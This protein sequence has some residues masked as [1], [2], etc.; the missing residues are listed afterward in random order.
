M[1]LL[2]NVIST[3]IAILGSSNRIVNSGGVFLILQEVRTIKTGIGELIVCQKYA[4]KYSGIQ[5]TES[6]CY[7][8]RLIR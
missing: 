2:R 8:V 5:N 1:Q 3:V 6:A 7:T 4:S